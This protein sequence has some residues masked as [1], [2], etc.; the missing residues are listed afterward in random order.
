[1]SEGVNANNASA[2]L[3]A[4]SENKRR[5]TNHRARPSATPSSVFIGRVCQASHSGP[6]LHPGHGIAIVGRLLPDLDGGTRQRQGQPI[7]PEWRVVDTPLKA[8]VLPGFESGKDVPGFVPGER[9][10]PDEP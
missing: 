9:L 4:P 3:A 8:T 2:T 5:V 1:M 6:G 7:A 10:R